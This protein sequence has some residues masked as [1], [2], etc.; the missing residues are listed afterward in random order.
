MDHQKTLEKE[1][2]RHKIE[3]YRAH[4]ELMK[5][6]NLTYQ[7]VADTLGYRYYYV[8]GVLN[9]RLHSKKALD[10]IE[11]LLLETAEIYL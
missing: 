5:G 2:K 1:R 8:W 9:G 3:P 6:L 4:I 7:N 10:Q 11:T